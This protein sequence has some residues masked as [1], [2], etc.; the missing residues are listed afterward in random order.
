ME[1]NSLEN[2]FNTIDYESVELIEPGVLKF[3]DNSN[4]PQYFSINKDIER[5]IYKNLGIS[6]SVS[7][8]VFSISD[9]IWKE[10][11]TSC[12]CRDENTDPFLFKNYKYI[13]FCNNLI[14]MSSVDSDIEKKISR[15]IA[16]C[17]SF[18][19]KIMYN[20]DS[21]LL[22][23]NLG[24]SENLV[25]IIEMDFY[26]GNY[27]LNFGSIENN[28][29]FITSSTLFDN[30]FGKF[31]S[32]DIDYEINL[33]MKLS[34]LNDNSKLYERASNISLS[35]REILDILKLSNIKIQTLND[36]SVL[37]DGNI[38]HKLVEYFNSTGQ[39]FKSLRSLSF[40][41]KSI[42]FTNKKVSLISM[43][44]YISNEYFSNDKVLLNGLDTM[45]KIC[46]NDISDFETL[47][48]SEDIKM[49]VNKN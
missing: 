20:E 47:K 1:I 43:M 42:K 18:E 9:S 33:A 24:L 14:T 41:N 31:I 38:P 10:L 15:F 22:K 49:L 19:S 16:I 5:E 26:K 17:N 25:A 28:V 7:N 21:Y 13:T 34:E 3:T 48:N 29:L 46:N 40:L 45:S 30:N 4:N 39:I 32:S 27:R 44:E 6:R 12:C 11:I 36:G 8:R 37:D 35:L 2:M 23:I